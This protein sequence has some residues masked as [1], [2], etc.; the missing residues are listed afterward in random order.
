MQKNAHIRYV[1]LDATTELHPSVRKGVVL[2]SSNGIA[3]CILL[4]PLEVQEAPTNR[5]IERR[6]PKADIDEIL[7]SPLWKQWG[8]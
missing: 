4:N 7:N 8:G 2:E 1:P 5:L 6:L 3:K